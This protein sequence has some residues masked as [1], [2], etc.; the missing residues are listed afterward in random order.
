MV[1]IELATA[2]SAPLPLNKYMDKISS[3]KGLKIA[4]KQCRILGKELH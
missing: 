3:H 2:A 4:P 1:T